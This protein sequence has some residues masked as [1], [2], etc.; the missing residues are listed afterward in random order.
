MRPGGKTDRAPGVERHR[1]DF[2]GIFGYTER[3]NRKIG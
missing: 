3:A 1:V 2:P